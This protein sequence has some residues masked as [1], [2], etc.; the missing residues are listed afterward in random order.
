MAPKSGRI[1]IANAS[2]DGKPACTQKYYEF[3]LRRLLEKTP[4]PGGTVLPPPR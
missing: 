1:W 2:S 3:N 4:G